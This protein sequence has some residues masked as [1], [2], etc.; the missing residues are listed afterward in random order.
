MNLKNIQTEV[1]A[2]FLY[3]LLAE[4][5]KDQNVKEIFLQMSAIEKSHAVAFL[6]K[7]G[8][9][10]KDMPKPSTRAK[11]LKKIGDWRFWDRIKF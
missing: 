8:L 9:T 6:Q 10:E 3:G 11:V 7:V 5:E 2:S 1:D 4:K